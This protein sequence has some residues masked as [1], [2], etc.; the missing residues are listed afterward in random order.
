M[1]T[2]T[3]RPRSAFLDR[4]LD[5]RSLRRPAALS[6]AANPLPVQVGIFFGKDLP[7]GRQRLGAHMVGRGHHDGEP[8]RIGV[9]PLSVERC[10]GSLDVRRDRSRG[11][12]RRC[13]DNTRC[14]CPR[15]RAQLRTCAIGAQLHGINPRNIT[16][17]FNRHGVDPSDRRTG[18]GATGHR[19]TDSQHQH[20]RPDKESPHSSHAAI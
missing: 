1:A 6:G 11:I 14:R 17:Q 20:R 15:L 3:G 19:K 9:D 4:E 18:G 8:P 16:G 13:H 5:R 10:H 2:P 12:Q 7:R